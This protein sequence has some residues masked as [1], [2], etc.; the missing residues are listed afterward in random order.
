MSCNN[1]HILFCLI[2]DMYCEHIDITIK[3][4]LQNY[5]RNSL[6]IKIE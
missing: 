2:L 3:Q 6:K 4:P 1:C 5:T